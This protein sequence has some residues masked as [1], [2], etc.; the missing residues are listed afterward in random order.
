MWLQDL[1]DESLPGGSEALSTSDMF[2]ASF[3]LPLASYLRVSNI[4]IPV[5]PTYAISREVYNSGPCPHFPEKKLE[6]ENTYIT[7]K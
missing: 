5:Y 1:E 4:S 6:T 7:P 2:F 3:L